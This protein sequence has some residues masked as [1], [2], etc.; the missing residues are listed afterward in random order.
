MW[1]VSEMTKAKIHLGRNVL[2][3]HDTIYMQIVGFRLKNWKK[4]KPVFNCKFTNKTHTNKTQTRFELTS[5]FHWKVATII[6]VQL[7]EIRKLNMHWP[8]MLL[9][10]FR[11]ARYLTNEILWNVEQDQNYIRLRRKKANISQLFIQNKTSISKACHCTMVSTLVFQLFKKQTIL[12]R[13]G[14][15]KK[16]EMHTDFPVSGKWHSFRRPTP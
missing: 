15:W 4:R 2:I 14:V 9:D 5:D 7:R 8:L 11:H 6:F 10:D 1:N 3:H 16:N 12:W 13:Y